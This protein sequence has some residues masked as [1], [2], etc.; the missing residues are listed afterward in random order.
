VDQVA[1]DMLVVLK[2]EVQVDL[3]V[4]V[5]SVKVRAEIVHAEKENR[6]VETAN[7]HN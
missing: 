6:S 2:E 5:D 3:A 4:V 7:V 1:A